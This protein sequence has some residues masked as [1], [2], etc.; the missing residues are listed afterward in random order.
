M[1]EDLVLFDE[2]GLDVLHQDYNPIII[3]PGQGRGGGDSRL[4]KLILG[5]DPGSRVTG[6]GLVQVTGDRFIH[7]D[8][9]VI[10]LPLNKGFSYRL[11]ALAENLRNLMTERHAHV[12]V[13]ER[14]FLGKN[15][16]SAFK[17]GHARG[18][19]LLAAAEAGVPVV[20]Y[21][22]RLVKKTVT[23]SGSASK[24]QVRFWVARELAIQV[25]NMDTEMDASDALA[26]ALAHA[27]QMA[28]EDR[29]RAQSRE[30]L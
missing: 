22:A 5:L 23:G 20:E 14:I 26:L 30:L 9:G 2:F 8:H 6:Y 18:I 28:V 10:H 11:K 12:A 17:L 16:D 24:D 27:R 29:F 13:V 19:C 21:A 25:A 4:S 7:V 15:A 3:G 1:Q